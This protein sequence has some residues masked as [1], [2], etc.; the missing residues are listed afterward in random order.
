MKKIL[1]VAA[2]SLMCGSAFAQST[3]APAAAQ[4]DM[5]KPGMNNNMT[6]PAPGASSSGNVGPGAT[7]TTMNQGTGNAQRNNMGGTT[8]NAMK[9]DASQQGAPTGAAVNSRGDSTQPGKVKD[10]ATR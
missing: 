5:N 8:G 3:G 10:G 9:P 4:S 2:L 7:G 1:A 6:Q